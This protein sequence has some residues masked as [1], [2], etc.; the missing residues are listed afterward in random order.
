[1]TVCWS[2]Q[3][4]FDVGYAHI[5]VKEASVMLCTGPQAAANPAACAG[6]NTLLGSYD[7]NTV[8][9]FSAQVRYNF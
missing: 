9:I 2:K 4:A 5:F 3:F 7:D 6:K 1:M 8:N